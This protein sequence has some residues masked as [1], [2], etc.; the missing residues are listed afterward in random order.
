M[1]V[2][3]QDF[4]WLLNYVKNLEERVQTLELKLMGF[5]RE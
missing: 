5:D 3:Q 4:N 2:N 1:N